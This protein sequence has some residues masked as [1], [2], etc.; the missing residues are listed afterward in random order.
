[1]KKALFLAFFALN[2]SFAV[3]NGEVQAN[4][5][6]VNGSAKDCEILGELY[7]YK[8]NYLQAVP[9]FQRSCELNRAIGCYNLAILYLNGHGVT[10][11]PATTRYYAK[12]AC[13]LGHQSGCEIYNKLK[14]FNNLW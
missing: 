2:L 7:A 1:M 10:Q 5:R 4:N 13:D 3:S 14:K 11:S 6:C 8:K 9:Y 12:K